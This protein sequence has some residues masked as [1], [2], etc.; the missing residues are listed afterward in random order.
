MSHTILVPLDG[1]P[2]AERALPVAERLARGAGG[3]LLLVRVARSEKPEPEAASGSAQRQDHRTEEEDYLR[4]AAETA[5][6]E[7]GVEVTAAVVYGGPSA[8]IL[9]AAVDHHATLIVMAT[10][11]RSGVGRWVYGS[12]ADEILRTAD[13]PVIVVPSDVHVG[14]SGSAQG[15]LRMVLALDGSDRAASLLEPVRRLAVELHAEI[16]LT[17]LVPDQPASVF[18]VVGGAP[19]MEYGSNAQ[20]DHAREYLEGIARQLQTSV[21]NVTVRCETGDPARRIAEIADDENADFIA[22][23]TRGRH[24]PQ[25]FFLGSVASA[26]LHR[27][28]MPVLIL[29]SG[30]TEPVVAEVPQ[31][32]DQRPAS[33]QP[34]EPS[35]RPLDFTAS[36]VELIVEGLRTLQWGEHPTPAEARAIDQLWRRLTSDLASSIGASTTVEQRSSR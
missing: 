6:Q 18:R 11:G 1:S 17:R 2:F 5:K 30:A 12:T 31:P 10:H 20:L 22:L 36:E 33:E 21:P 3:R 8:S 7:T 34:V 35:G 19:V 16:V 15:P 32:L 14:R 26:T 4:H 25:R 9:T 24:G 27:A 13:L 28:R 23:V 29:R